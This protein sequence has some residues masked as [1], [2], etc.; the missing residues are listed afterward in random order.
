MNDVP[1]SPATDRFCIECRT[2]IPDDA[3]KCTACGSYQD[4]RRHISTT[5]GLVGLA[6]GAIGIATALVSWEAPRRDYSSTT[7]E[8]AHP[9]SSSAFYVTNDGTRPSRVGVAHYAFSHRTDP[10]HDFELP[11]GFGPP[12]DALVDADGEPKT[13]RLSLEYF[14]TNQF[15]KNGGS[16]IP[17]E[18]RE[19]RNNFACSVEVE[20]LE[21]GT[22]EPRLEAFA[23]DTC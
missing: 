14:F 9:R 18:V 23:F 2:S 16:R 19:Y 21:Y 5:T 10:S 22:Q 1:K 15:E 17:I 20:I 11:L 7:I 4:W 3:T 8:P 6:I 12:E 13:F